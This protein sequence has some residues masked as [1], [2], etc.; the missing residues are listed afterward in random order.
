MTSNGAIGWPRKEVYH[1]Q[2]FTENLE[3]YCPGGYHPTHLGDIFHGRYRVIH[4]LGWGSYSVVWLARDLEVQRNVALKIII[5][6]QS[7]TSTEATTLRALH[8]GDENH[9]GFPFICHLLDEF[10]FDGP[11]GRHRCLVLRATGCSVADSQDESNK[12]PIHVAR[13]ISVQALLGL[14]YIHSCGVVHGDLHRG[15][16][17]FQRPE[18]EHWTEEE[19][20]ENLGEPE[21]EPVE[22]LDKKP[23]GK[24]AP[25]YSV[26]L[27][28][29]GMRSKELAESTRITISDFGQSFFAADNHDSLQ[30]PRRYAPPEHFFKDHLGPAVDVWTVGLSIYTILSAHSLFEAFYPNPDVII[31]EM[32]D[33][34]GHPP[35]RWW[36]SWEKKHEF[37]A[38][39]GSL[40]KG[41]PRPLAVR[42]KRAG[43]TIGN[44]EQKS[45]E[46]LL[47]GRRSEQGGY[48][49]GG[50]LEYE[51]SRRMTANDAIMSDWV[52]RWAMP[53]FERA[54]TSQR[55]KVPRS[56][57][58]SD[59]L[60]ASKSTVE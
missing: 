16:L 52:T 56:A 38:A 49:S 18:L 19:V 22:R 39:D 60:V 37:F 51:P 46:Q 32:V 34:L 13:S 58:N 40:V 9:P 54:V 8:A 42:L 24:E 48:V 20:F 53:A 57:Q 28:I 50:M 25:D 44:N 21:T 36:N 27:A 4:K 5:A 29:V 2:E 7:E 55:D 47:R 10:C 1:W 15:N 35:D 30:T 17:L 33:T 14:S 3:R 26:T 59:P 6:E 23:H 11:N 43:D 41:S 45:L 12:F 31:A